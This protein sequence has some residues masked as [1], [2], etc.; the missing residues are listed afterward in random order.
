[1]SNRE[2]SEGRVAVHYLTTL[3][4]ISIY[5]VQV[6]PFIEGLTPLQL[7]TP[8]I[9]IVG[10]QYL[11]HRILSK[12]WV[13][14]AP[15]E[16]QVKR[17]FQ[18]EL[19]L[20]L[21]SG[22]ILTISNGFVYDFPIASGLKMILGFVTLGLFIAIDVA[23]ARER[24]LAIYIEKEGVRLRPNDKY[25]PLVGKFA[26]LAG[27]TIVFI[28][29]IFFLMVVKDLDWLSRVGD[30]I[31]IATAQLSIMKEFAFIGGVLLLYVM[32]VI[33]SY[34]HNLNLFIN[35][36]NRVLVRATDGDLSGVVTIS[37]NDEFGV[38]A[39]HTNV[40]IKTLLN[41]TQ[42]L[43]RTQDVTIMSLA[44]LAET[45]DNE[46][47]AHIRRTQRYVKVLA[48]Q[49]RHHPRFNHEL[50]DK[51]IELLYKS[52]PLHDIGKVGIPDRILLKPGKLDAEEF[53]IMKT[54]AELGGEALKVAENE[55][56]STSFLE[57]AREIATTHHEKWN[58]KGY[59]KGLKGDEIPISGRLM[60]VADVYDALITKRVYKE[61][62]SHQDA[63]AILKE[64][65]GEHFDPDVLDALLAI[66][67]Q[68]VNIANE[69]TDA[70]ESE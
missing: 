1:M 66:E 55:L 35:N 3:I 63:M 59:P 53:T 39:H 23:L 58:G 12:R 49:L 54:H 67:Q 47:G 70:D 9:L 14:N 56:G 41:R 31:P 68:F 22:I 51:S 50:N 27:I 62:F 26:L 48:E 17:T 57:Y 52:A 45:R 16:Q 34:A 6:C 21:L 65:K 37:S 4:F 10:F 5:G 19:S 20:F 36:Q 38:M 69:F 64:G 61:A 44:S 11:L 42:E 46:T 25:F 43:Q 24:S 33:F 2:S 40:M 28:I 7:A 18:L 32:N 29:G 8:L 60:A 15:L 30:D 13:V